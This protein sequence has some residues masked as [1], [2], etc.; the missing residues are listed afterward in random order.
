MIP[1]ALKFSSPRVTIF[2][3][4][5][6][7]RGRLALGR[8]KQHQFVPETK[9][10]RIEYIILF[11]SHLQKQKDQQDGY[12]ANFQTI[13]RCKFWLLVKKEALLLGIFLC[14][15][16]ITTTLD[17]PSPPPPSPKKSFQITPIK[18]LNWLYRTL[19]EVFT[20][21]VLAEVQP[22]IWNAY[23][24]NFNCFNWHH[25]SAI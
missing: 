2:L 4:H 13:M 18:L 7:S 25:Q 16:K 5:S 12:I 8:C 23:K 22:I 10:H 3:H 14:Y 9:R 1:L 17:S 19:E 11:G 20:L 21:S 15:H 6:H 24:G